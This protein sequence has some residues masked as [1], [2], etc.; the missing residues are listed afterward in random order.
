MGIDHGGSRRNLL[1]NGSE[2]RADGR[3]QDLP[4][5]ATPALAAL[6]ATSLLV[7][8]IPAV[9]GPTHHPE[10]SSLAYLVDDSLDASR[11]EGDSV[12]SDSVS[13]E[14]DS[15]TVRRVGGRWL[16]VPGPG[17]EWARS[18]AAE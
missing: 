16:T 11:L 2:P 8:T 12:F 3:S 10:F 15:S 13:S 5:G 18:W 4:W 1:D 6:G 9:S 14:S 17:E 7:S